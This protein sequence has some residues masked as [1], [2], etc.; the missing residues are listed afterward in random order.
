MDSFCEMISIANELEQ[1]QL[2]RCKQ[3]ETINIQSTEVTKRIENKELMLNIFQELKEIS[4]KLD[5]IFAEIEN[6]NS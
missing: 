2:R 5:E 3:I 1:M 4:K 6:L